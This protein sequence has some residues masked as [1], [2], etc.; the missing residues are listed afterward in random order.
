MSMVPV[1]LQPITYSVKQFS[2]SECRFHPKIF[3]PLISKVYPLGSKSELMNKVIWVAGGG[4]ILLSRIMA[5]PWLKTTR[6]CCQVVIF[7]MIHR[8]AYLTRL[9]ARI[10][11]SLVFR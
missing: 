4:M 8:N 10:L 5:K 7:F 1:Q 11:L 3:F 6:N 2:D 9:T